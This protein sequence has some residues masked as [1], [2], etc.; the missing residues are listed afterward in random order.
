MKK[1]I[2]IMIGAA[3]LA[4]LCLVFSFMAYRQYADAN[5]S[6]EAFDN[7]A[8]LVVEDTLPEMTEPDV[9]PDSNGATE[10]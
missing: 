4:A 10:E 7:I 5:E 8:A 1:H 9:L 3:V 2:I 6:A